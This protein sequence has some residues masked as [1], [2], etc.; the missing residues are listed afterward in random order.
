MKILL[1][2]YAYP[3]ISSPGAMRVAHFAKDLTDFG[4]NVSVLTTEDGYS[5]MISGTT[6]P[7]FFEGIEIIRVKDLLN[8]KQAGESLKNISNTSFKQ[9]LKGKLIKIAN[10]MIFPDRDITWYFPARISQL[11]AKNFDVVIGS[12]PST[13]NLILAN[14]LAKKFKAKLVLD[15]RD[16]WV[17]D[18]NFYKKSPLRKFFELKIE[19]TLN[20]N[21]SLVTSVSRFN[22]KILQ[23]K[24]TCKV[25]TV[26]NGYDQ[27]LISTLKKRQ[28]S[29]EVFVLAYAGSFYNGERDPLQLLHALVK[30]RIEGVITSENFNF[31]IYGNKEAFL[32]KSIESLGIS[33]L[34]KFHGMREQKS[35]LEE[36]TS[37]N[38]LLTVT[39]KQ[40]ISKGE[41]TTKLFEY[42]ALERPCICLTKPGFEIADTLADIEHASVIDIDDVDSIYLSIKKSI[43]NWKEN[44][45]ES[46]NFCHKQFSRKAGSERLKKCLEN[47]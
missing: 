5:S 36:L 40:S 33:D 37:A 17:E 12:Y 10:G 2:S 34:V 42:L 43:K 28:A 27:E 19:K 14:S 7:Y 11:K 13:T 26:Y 3:P 24:V 45:V 4:Y 30:L 15:M 6:P 23:K 20:R 35:L 41:M 39:R 21:A 9:R 31:S 1:V 16:L 46:I 29:N 25:E 47:L 22:T 18:H 38:I 8:K 44:G 32:E